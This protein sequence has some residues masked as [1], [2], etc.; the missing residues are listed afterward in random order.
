MTMKQSG[1]ILLLDETQAG[2]L[3]L[4]REV[5][6]AGYAVA[7]EASSPQEA[8]AIANDVHPDLVLAT[9]EE[10]LLRALK[11]IETVAA[12]LPE[13]PVVSVSSRSS[14]ELF[15][16]AV[17]VGA[18]DLLARPL[19]AEELTESLNF[20]LLQAERRRRGSG[21]DP[22]RMIQGTV[23]SIFGPKGG[24]GKTTLATNLGV[25]IASAGQHRVL[26]VDL[27]TQ[28]A[29]AAVALGM[30]PQRTIFDLIDNLGHTDRDL[31]K[32][33]VT[34]HPSGLEVLAAPAWGTE[35]RELT[36]EDVERLLNL[37]AAHYD[38]V[39]IDTPGHIN[40]VVLRALQI[41]TYALCVTSLEIASIQACRRVLDYM[42]DWE[43]AKD[44]IKVISNTPNA[45]NSLGKADIEAALERPVFW[46]IPFDPQVGTAGQLGQA[47]VLASP[48]SKA[49]RSVVQL[50][51]TLAGSKPPAR[52]G[53][54]GILAGWRR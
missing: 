52:E 22:A 31:L 13:T 16:K 17:L 1:G 7:G 24:V 28:I 19:K 49:A 27:D 26:V 35:D 37:V 50:H 23:I 53:L 36:P 43:F 33:F 15:R 20:A 39:I 6:A 38:Y 45:A 21:G 4:H 34:L 14:R 47:V 46:E 18:H 12:G 42:A 40:P 9:L 8:L 30:M 11:T 2:R 3:Q 48:T 29:A 10:P 25:S 32:T 51:Y 41:S 54:L 5:A 44:K